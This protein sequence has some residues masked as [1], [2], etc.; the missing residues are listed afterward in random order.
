MYARVLVGCISAVQDDY[1]RFII[2]WHWYARMG[3]SD[4]SDAPDD[5][6]SFTQF[7]YASVKYKPRLLNDSDPC[8][9]SGNSDFLAE[10]GMTHA[11]GGS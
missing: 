4:V 8:Y 6:L 3:A 7:D 11:R 10:N 5:A 2:A 1:S 9:V